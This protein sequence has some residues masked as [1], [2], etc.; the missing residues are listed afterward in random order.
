[1]VGR[2]ALAGQEGVEGLGREELLSM[3]RFGCDRIFQV[4]RVCVCVG[5]WLGGEGWGE[6]VLQWL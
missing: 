2:G 5:G 3:L 6:A 4:G 1:M